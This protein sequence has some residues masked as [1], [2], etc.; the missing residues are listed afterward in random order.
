[1]AWGLNSGGELGG[2]MAKACGLEDVHGIR[3]IQFCFEAGSIATMTID[4]FPSQ[5]EINAATAVL[6]EAITERYELRKV[7]N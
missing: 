7:E 3:S 5:D 6:G 2:L 1:M 4:R